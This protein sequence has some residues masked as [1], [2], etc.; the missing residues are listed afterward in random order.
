MSDARATRTLPS[1]RHL[2]AWGVAAVAAASAACGGGGPSAAVPAATATEAE[3]RALAAARPS[4]LDGS[5][6]V[7]VGEI[8]LID[9]NPWGLSSTLDVPLGLSEL[10][11]AGLLRRRDVHFV[12]RRRF[13]VAADRERRGLARPQ[14]APPVGISPGAEMILAGSWAALGLDSAYL[15]MRLV[16]TETGDVVRTWRSATANGADPISLARTIVGGLLAGLDAMGRRPSWSDPI[17][18]SA[19]ATYRATTVPQQS[20][21]GF[22]RGLAAEERW[23][24]EAARRGY[25]AAAVG[26]FFEAEVALARAARLRLGGTLGES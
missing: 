1:D 26:G 5:V 10:V 7:T 22:L 16:D 2:R 14:R 11:V 18:T 24:W 8:R 13:A 12:E 15:E 17:P 6:R 23:D 3:W 20:V 25:Q 4:P 21:E 9:P 19:P